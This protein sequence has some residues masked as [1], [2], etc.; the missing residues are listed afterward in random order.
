MEMPTAEIVPGTLWRKSG[1]IEHVKRGMGMGSFKTGPQ[2]RLG[3]CRACLVAALLVGCGTSAE[4]PQSR[5]KVGEILVNS[6]GHVVR[7]EHAFRTAEPNALLDGVVRVEGKVGQRLLEINA[8]CSMPNIPGWPR[9]DNLF[10]R[11]IQRVEDAKGAT[12]TTQWQTL[13]HFDGRVESRMGTTPG[14]WLARL[15]DNLCRRG[16]FDDRPIKR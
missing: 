2:P 11:P 13:F 1:V 12:G 5:A 4:Q 10:G 8:V 7:L 15:R 6:Q 9:Y 16:D 3:A 14:P